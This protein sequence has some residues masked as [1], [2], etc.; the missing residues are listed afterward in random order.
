MMK[1]ELS[2]NK[3]SLLHL[4]LVQTC[5]FSSQTFTIIKLYFYAEARISLQLFSSQ[6]NV[7]I[8]DFTV[9]LCTLRLVCWLNFTKVNFSLVNYNYLDDVVRP[10]VVIVVV[11]GIRQPTPFIVPQGTNVV[12]QVLAYPENTNLRGRIT[13]QLISSIFC[14]DSAPLLM[15][16]SN[17]TC[18]VKSRPVKQEFS[19]T[20][21][22]PFMVSVLWGI[23]LLLSQYL[24]QHFPR[25]SVKTFL[26]QLS[27]QEQLKV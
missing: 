16:N 25:L 24:L 12:K 27:K 14:L 5:A 1:C 9:S 6:V 2:N 3:K 11:V 18:L 26:C 15:L 20:E 19:L 4:W 10:H 13:V 21:I 23:Q 8:C 17:L 7:M 22:L